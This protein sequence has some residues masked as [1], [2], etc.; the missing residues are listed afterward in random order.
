MGLGTGWKPNFLRFSGLIKVWK[1]ETLTKP[2]TREK[3]RVMNSDCDMRTK[4]FPQLHH[5]FFC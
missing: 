3:I 1:P 2:E 4:L 5:L